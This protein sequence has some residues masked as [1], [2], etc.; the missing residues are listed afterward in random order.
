MAGRPPDFAA[1]VASCA[2]SD[3]CWEWPGTISAAGYG[4]LRSGGKKVYAHRLSYEL[5]KGP[6]PCGLEIDHLCRNR[7]CANPAHLEAVSRRENILRGDGPRLLA[8]RHAAKTHCPA[9]HPYDEANTSR[10]RLSRKRKC[11]ACD[12]ERARRRR[13]A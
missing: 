12:R 1:F 9:G 7:K 13:A 8:M 11:R 10:D 3:A 5:H 6:I 2:A 4:T